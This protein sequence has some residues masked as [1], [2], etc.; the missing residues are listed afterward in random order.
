[1][2]GPYERG[3]SPP[4]PALPT[5]RE[6]R[7]KVSERPSRRHSTPTARRARRDVWPSGR[8]SPCRRRRRRARG[9]ATGDAPVARRV[10]SR[11]RSSSAPPWPTHG[12][13]LA[14]W[15]GSWL[16][17]GGSAHLATI[18]TL[19]EAGAVAAILTGLLINARLLVYSASLARR[20]REQPRWFRVVAAGLIIDPTWAA[21]ERHAEAVRR[22]AS[23]TSLLHRGRPHARHRMVGRD[24]ASGR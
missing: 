21:A 1:M 5:A 14:G 19:D 11:S 15:A 13:P 6:G 20:W 24:R 17:Y 7:R 10:R 22:P 9:P 2:G 3:P 4:L 18:R 16:I 8:T 23:A 12:S